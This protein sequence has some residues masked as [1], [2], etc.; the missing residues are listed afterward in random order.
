MKAVNL[1]E[2]ELCI[3]R[4]RFSRGGDFCTVKL[5][6][7]PTGEF[8]HVLAKFSHVVWVLPVFV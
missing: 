2:R 6:I 7:S 1:F 4:L 3:M 8:G 5:V